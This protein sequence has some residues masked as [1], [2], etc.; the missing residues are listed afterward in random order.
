M[1]SGVLFTLCH[2]NEDYKI[3]EV[4]MKRVDKELHRIYDAWLQLG[5]TDKYERIPDMQFK[6]EPV[7]RRVCE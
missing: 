6:G 2:P 7:Y 1:L 4:L 5:A 3:D